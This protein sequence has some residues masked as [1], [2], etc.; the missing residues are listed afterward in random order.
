MSEEASAPRQGASPVT[1]ASCQLRGRGCAGAVRAASR[2]PP[3]TWGGPE[4]DNCLC[5]SWCIILEVFKEKSAQGRPIV[6]GMSRILLAGEAGPALRS[7][8]HL[9]TEGTK[10][11]GTREKQQGLWSTRWGFLGLL[12]FIPGT[13]DVLS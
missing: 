1:A 13:E 4:T 3:C 6:Q 10:N 9:R 8:W 5:C 12:F 2:K 11:M 7:L